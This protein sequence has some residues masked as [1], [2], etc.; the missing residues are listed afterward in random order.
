MLRGATLCRTSAVTSVS[1]VSD[2]FIPDENA[3]AA[4]W[5]IGHRFHRLGMRRIVAPASIYRID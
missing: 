1:S 4:P 3:L 2:A 5:R